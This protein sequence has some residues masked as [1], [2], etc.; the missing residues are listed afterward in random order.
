[1]CVT[2]FVYPCIM[3]PL[4]AAYYPLMCN[5]NSKW[6]YLK[7][8]PLKA[9]KGRSVLPSPKTGNTGR[10]VFWKNRVYRFYSEATHERESCC[11]VNKEY[12]QHTD[13]RLSPRSLHW[14][15][16]A[17]PAHSTNAPWSLGPSLNLSSFVSSLRFLPVT[18]LNF[19]FSIPFTSRSR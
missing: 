19:D 4:L 14:P 8:K 12:G 15:G 16:Q 10:Y 2:R 11:S 17:T 3:N 1:M 6:L 5:K 7:M 9:R 13:N 18:N